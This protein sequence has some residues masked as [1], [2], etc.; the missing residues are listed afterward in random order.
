MSAGNEAWG[1]AVAQALS[2]EAPELAAGVNTVPELLSALASQGFDAA[3][4]GRIASERARTGQP[5]PFPLAGPQLRQAGAAR[6]HAALTEARTMLGLDGRV[7]APPSNRTQLN[8]EEARLM[9][10]VPPHHGA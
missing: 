2:G 5:W 7:A 1:R 10:E 3:R 6:V 4:L 8:A 9:R